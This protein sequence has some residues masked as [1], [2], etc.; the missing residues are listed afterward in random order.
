MKKYCLI[1]GNHFE[2]VEGIAQLDLL[3]RAGITVDTYGVGDFT[4]TARS[5]LKIETDRIFMKESDIGI[6]DYDGILLPGGPG[7]QELLKNE[8]L[9][10]VVREFYDAG[11]LVFAICA[12]PLLLDKAGI[13]N[14]KNFT[15]YPDEIENIHSGT[16]LDERVVVDGN[17]VTSQGVGTSLDAAIKLVEIIVSKEEADS[18]A[19]KIVYHS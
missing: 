10:R 2:D 12:A 19:R 9:I 14:G 8:A 4:I 16:R 17:L 7:V 6:N 11:R 3:R 13:L 5:G 18:L 1:F 15:C